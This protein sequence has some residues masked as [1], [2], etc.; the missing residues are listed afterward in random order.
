MPF[1]LNY[2]F[3]LSLSAAVL[4]IATFVT[5]SVRS[6]PFREKALKRFGSVERGKIDDQQ[7]NCQ[8]N[9]PKKTVMQILNLSK[10]LRNINR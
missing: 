9:I 7:R 8:S 2:V 3:A 10:D 4:R 1:A 5:A 6:L